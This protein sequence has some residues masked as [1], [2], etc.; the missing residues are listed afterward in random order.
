MQEEEKCLRE[1]ER[2]RFELQERLFKSCELQVA[3]ACARRER[4]R[5]LEEEAANE[6]MER[7][8]MLDEMARMDKLEQLG[9]ERERRKKAEHRV[10]VEALLKQRQKQREDEIAEIQ[11]QQK[12]NEKEQEIRKMVGSPGSFSALCSALL[13]WSSFLMWQPSSTGVLSLHQAVAQGMLPPGS[14]ILHGHLA[15][16]AVLAQLAYRVG[17]EVL[18]FSPD[19]GR[20]SIFCNC[21][22]SHPPPCGATR[23]LAPC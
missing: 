7:Q 23:R 4:M 17:R 3:E 14:R 13:R 18:S 9:G 1:E 2:V 10:A 22:P 11:Q 5:K 20:F 19:S 16:N 21:F 12:F 6:A 8:R 15:P